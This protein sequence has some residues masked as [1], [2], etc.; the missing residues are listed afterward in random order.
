MSVFKNSRSALIAGAVAATALFS[1]GSANA[2][3]LNSWTNI[4]NNVGTNIGSQLGVD[5]TDAGSGRVQFHVTNNVGIAS[6][7]AQIYFDDK[8]TSSLGSFFSLTGST[9][10]AFS[11][12]AN[13]SNVPSG[14]TINF[15]ADF[16]TGANNPAPQNGINTASEYLDIVFNLAAGKTFNDLLTQIGSGE[17]VLGMHV[18][19]IAGGSSD[20]YINTPPTTQVPEPATLALL[21]MGLI[22]L[23]VIR[24][25]KA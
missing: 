11:V 12:G 14:S 22:G 9:G 19:G 6:V 18:T 20:S 23:G 10:V 4:T 17:L 24:R 3:L 2:V 16:A 25:R 13:P 5:V 8:S 21:G 7:I 1:A 15:D